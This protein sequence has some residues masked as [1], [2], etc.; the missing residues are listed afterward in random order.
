[1]QSILLQLLTIAA[2]LC[3]G[4]LTARMLG[5]SG[6]GLYAAATTWPSVLGMVAVAGIANGVLV[7]LRRR[8]ETKAAVIVWGGLVALTL[9][10]LLAAIAWF[11]LPHLLGEHYQAAL[12]TAAAAL[13]LIHL[14]ALGALTRQ[15]FAGRGRFLLSNL[16]GFLPHLLHA[17]AI[18]AFA[19]AGALTVETAVAG[20]VLGCAGA[21]L[22]LLPFLIREMKGPLVRIRRAG[23][24]LW[25]F[26][27]RAAPADLLALFASWTDRILLILLLPADQLGLYAV[28]FGFSR[29][30]TVVTPATGI[31]LSAMAHGSAEEA[32]R[33]HD[34]AL[35]LSIAGVSVLVFLVYLMDRQLLRLVYGAEFEAALGIFRILVL[36]AVA[37]R[38]AAVTSQ[39]YLASNRPGL[40][41][42]FCL[43]DVAVSVGLML[44]LVPFYGAQG[45]A[46]ALLAGTAL[47]LG[48]L[49]SG[50]L[51]HL[52]LPLPRLW[53][54]FADVREIRTLFRS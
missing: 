49:W 17:L 33:L 44:A 19:L 34:M 11:W 40:N 51:F 27:R 2:N 28:A 29:A 54:T 25:D 50:V 14:V 26:A 42:W 12:H 46:W 24:E 32:K 31:M 18:S 37:S 7:Q 21:Q 48:L 53:L 38:I 9:S 47:R 20:L 15:V 10:T 23:I 36:Q 6:R 35:R 1:L 3:T 30:V 45:A 41:S 16:A 43:L 5:V 4:V 52:R 8:P 13:V 22:L 39:L